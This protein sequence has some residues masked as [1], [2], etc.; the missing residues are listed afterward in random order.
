MKEIAAL[1][2]AVAVVGS[3]GLLLSPMLADVGASLGTPSTSVAWAMSAYGAGTALSSLFLAPWIDHLG[4]RLSLLIGMAALMA[5]M[6][7]S[8]I[9]GRLVVLVAGQLIAGLGA[10]LVFPA[11][12]AT[13]TALT[14]PAQ[15]S[16]SLGRVLMGWSL[17]LVGGVPLA[18]LIAE[19][20]NWRIS[21][22]LLALCAGAVVVAISGFPDR[23]HHAQRPSS[24][25]NIFATVTLP[26]VP[27][28]LAIVL[29]YTG[30]FYGVYAFLTRE[31]QSA[32]AVST[33]KAGIVVLMFGVGF[34]LAAFANR[35][36]D[37]LGPKRL[38]PIALFANGVLYVL[39]APAMH[40]F[41]TILVVAL[42]WGFVNQFCLNMIVLLSTQN[43]PEARGAILGLNSATTYFGLMSGTAV[44]S[45][46]YKQEGFSALILVAAILQ[47][48]AAVIYLLIRKN[49][50]L[51]KRL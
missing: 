26:G 25:A 14:P 1:M 12:Y 41:A 2:V 40:S 43:W 48:L 31:T 9:A 47:I 44:A 27:P 49:A 34:A 29:A 17:S 36:V 28:M 42:A 45:H 4:T 22:V 39:M 37:L 7:A 30:S 33:S 3:N 5:S 35:A 11:A 46:L 51:E 23:P 8:A 10:G 21:Y 24:R 20:L 13:A 16:Q 19:K 38:F 15:A 18:A 50:G 32:L 6:L